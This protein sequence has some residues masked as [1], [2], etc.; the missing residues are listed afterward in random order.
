MKTCRHETSSRDQGQEDRNVETHELTHEDD[1]RYR[2][3]RCQNQLPSRTPLNPYALAHGI[4]NIDILFP[5]A[6]PTDAQPEWISRRMEWVAGVLGGTRHTPF[7]R[8]KTRSADITVE[9]ARAKGYVKGT[10]KKEEFFALTQRVTTPTTIYK[11]QK[12]DR[13]DIVDITD[14]D[15]VAWLKGEMR[16]MLEGKKVGRAVLDR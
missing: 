6:E 1:A 16:L 5:D 3:R 15:V 12:L 8:I 11:K 14:F 2:R 4:E 10:L 13:D 9:E 7:S